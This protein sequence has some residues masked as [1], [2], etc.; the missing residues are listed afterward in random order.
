M[1]LHT[2]HSRNGAMA[3]CAEEQRNL[4]ELIVG[5]VT[6]YRPAQP[7]RELI[8]ANGPIED[9]NDPVQAHFLTGLSLSLSLFLSASVIVEPS[10][11]SACCTSS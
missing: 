3:M 4:L 10:H 7:V 11:C 9:L 5:E 2:H 1:H 6:R 8:A